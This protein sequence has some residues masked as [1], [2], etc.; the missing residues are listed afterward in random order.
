[1]HIVLAFL[2]IIKAYTGIDTCMLEGVLTFV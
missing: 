1:M 2:N